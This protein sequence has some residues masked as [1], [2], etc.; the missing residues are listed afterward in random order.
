M[1]YIHRKSKLS[2]QINKLINERQI[3]IYEQRR[4]IEEIL[5]LKNQWRMIENAYYRLQR[6]MEYHINNN[7]Q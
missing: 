4:N 1:L 2:V 5:L 6:L 7:V 3:L